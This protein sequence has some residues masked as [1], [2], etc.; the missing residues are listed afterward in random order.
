MSNQEPKWRVVRVI[1]LIEVMDERRI[2]TLTKL[3]PR[4]LDTELSSQ[5]TETFEIERES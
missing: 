1:R 4:R 5:M 3:R 2:R